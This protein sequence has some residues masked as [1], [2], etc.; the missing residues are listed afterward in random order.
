M[1]TP[2][3]WECLTIEIRLHQT[4]KAISHA[5]C[6]KGESNAGARCLDDKCYYRD[7]RD[8]LG[9]G[10][11]ANGG[12]PRKRDGQARPR[13]HQCRRRRQSRRCLGS[14][15]FGRRRKCRDNQS[16]YLSLSITMR[17]LATKTPAIPFRPVAIQSVTKI[18]LSFHC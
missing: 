12:K 4:S 8:D 9:G 7:F 14:C 18:C 13:L 6:E 5:E 17:Y 1:R 15:R 3:C 2:K 10:H 11:R 16:R